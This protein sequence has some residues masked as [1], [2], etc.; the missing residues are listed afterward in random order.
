M[1]RLP[2]LGLD[3]AAPIDG[4]FYAWRDISRHSSD[5][6]QFARKMLA[7]TLAA[8]TPGHNFDP[9]EGR[10]FMGFSY[11]GRPSDM[12]EALDRIEKWL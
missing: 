10:R 4:A 5:S 9:V 3:L 1:D 11:A 12:A 6:M 8:A 2:R 7:D